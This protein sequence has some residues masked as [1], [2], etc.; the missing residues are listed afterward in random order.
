[1]FDIG[2]TELLVIGIVAL[3]VVGPKDLPRMLR[4]F[5]Q[6][7]GKARSMARE[8]QQQ[9][10]EAAD[11]AGLDE[12]RKGISSAENAVKSNTFADAF[13]DISKAGDDVKSELNKTVSDKSGTES[14]TEISGTDA[15][16][17]KPVS[18]EADTAGTETET[19]AAETDP[20]KPTSVADEGA[21][22]PAVRS[23]SA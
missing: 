2:A 5:G 4:T 12:V 18:K 16:E 1:M 15:P 17:T 8:F 14:G 11:E 6:F 9:F 19:A 22:E 23:G 10:T 21:A 7:V 13:S 20:V 3:L